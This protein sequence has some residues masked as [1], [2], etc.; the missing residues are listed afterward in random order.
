MKLQNSR[1]TDLLLLA[2]YFFLY[3]LLIP[4]LLAFAAESSAFF[5]KNSMAFYGLA[6]L[7]TLLIFFGVKRK[8]LREDFTKF[9][10]RFGK[11][12]RVI[13][14]AQLIIFLCNIPINLVLMKIGIHNQNQ[15][16]LGDLA[17]GGYLWFLV[18]LALFFAPVVEEL[19]F[20]NIL[21]NRIYG[22]SPV[23]A[24]IISILS[25]SMLHGAAALRGGK[26]QDFIA[27]LSYVPLSFFLCRLYATRKSMAFPIA[28]HFLNNSIAVIL[29]LVLKTA[30]GV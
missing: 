5:Q 10:E 20:R 8:M 30:T 4:V 23:L 1:K 29:L 2:V 27:I 7:L 25:F 26:P 15:N 21:F 3:L 12:L 16:M 18:F 13:I 28:L 22:K 19:V 24:Y 14:L 9:R 11:N 6:G 17:E